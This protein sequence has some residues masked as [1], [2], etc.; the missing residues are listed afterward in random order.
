MAFK[1]NPAL[2]AYGKSAGDNRVMKMDK[3][4]RMD[5][6]A[7][8]RAGYYEYDVDGNKKRITKAEYKEKENA[9]ASSTA[10]AG[11]ADEKGESGNIVAD[12]SHG[13]EII[14]KEAPE[15]QKAPE[16]KDAVAEGTKPRNKRGA[17]MRTTQ[18]T[19]YKEDAK[20]QAKFDRE[21]GSGKPS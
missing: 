10:T 14:D 1:M 6:S 15:A 18:T 7:M 21:S 5:P 2:K 16:Y 11:V 3:A 19:R 12:M 4:M 20:T 13:K 9:G 17:N 8:K